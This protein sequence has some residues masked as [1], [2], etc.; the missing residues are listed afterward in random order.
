MEAKERSAPTPDQPDA[1][2]AWHRRYTSLVQEIIAAG[3]LPK[4]AGAK[5]REVIR[6]E[7]SQKFPGVPLPA[8]LP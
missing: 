2:F 4:D 3:L 8:F 7:F 5:A 6:S 1:K